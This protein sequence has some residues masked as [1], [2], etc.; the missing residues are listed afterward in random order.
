M[1]TTFPLPL[2]AYIDLTGGPPF[3]EGLTREQLGYLGCV[4]FAIGDNEVDKLLGF[5][6]RHVSVQ[7]YVNATNISTLDSIISILDAGAHRVFVQLSRLADLESYGGRVALATSQYET[8]L[9]PNNEHGVL[10]ASKDGSIVYG[11][12]LES[13]AETKTSSISTYTSSKGNTQAYVDLARRHSAIP[14]IPA[15]KLTVD[16]GNKDDLLSVPAI[17]G[18][19]WVSDR[20]DHLI[21]T[22]VTDERGIALGLAYSSQESLSESLKSGKGEAVRFQGFYPK[23]S[24]V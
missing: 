15:T 19:C 14:I 8:D 24:N 17:I 21:P 4:Y 13:C 9:S 20:S 11:S 10:V 2:I 1:E 12:V 18:K 6:R 16:N 5:L 3:Q 23:F 7:A 22:L